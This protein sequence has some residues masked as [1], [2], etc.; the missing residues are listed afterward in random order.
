LEAA[1]AFVANVATLSIGILELGGLS[2]KQKLPK[3]QIIFTANR[4]VHIR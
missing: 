4:M 2:I 3:V 1:D